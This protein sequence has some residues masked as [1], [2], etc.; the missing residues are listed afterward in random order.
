M[1]LLK[2]PLEAW[3]MFLIFALIVVIGTAS[4]FIKW[5]P[6]L[7]SNR[8][9]IDQ[10]MNVLFIITGIFFVL[11]QGL[12][13]YF[14]WKYSDQNKERSTYI[15]GS[16]ALEVT[17]TLGTAIILAVLGIWGVKVWK[18][19]VIQAP[20]PNALQVEVVA[21]QFS[22]SFLYPGP[23]GV[24]GKLNP[25]YISFLNPLGIDPKD[26]AGKQDVWTKDDLYLPVGKPVVLR[27]RSLDVVHSFFVPAFR[28]KQDAVPG[29][30]ISTWFIPEKKGKYE[31]ACSQFCGRGHYTM[32][33]TCFV[34]SNV[35]FQKELAHLRKEDEGE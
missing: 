28:V 4:F 1:K 16:Y 26:S 34:V 25:K 15:P 23:D 14:I 31:I 24:F 33:G 2:R 9:S 29:M 17:W 19:T 3:G 12:T 18:K 10:M 13:G 6:P 8:I 7:A 20:P 27:I 30:T 32:R 11:V 21:Q 35:R 5:M 22:W